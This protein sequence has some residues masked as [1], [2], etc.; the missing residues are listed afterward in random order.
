MKIYRDFDE[1]KLHDTVVA[2][3]KFD[4][5]HKGHMQLLKTCLN[6]QKQ[7][8]QSAVF[9][10]DASI[11]TIMPDTDGFLN[12]S[13]ERAWL[14]QC[15]G[16]EQLAEYS[17][18]KLSGMTPEAFVRDILVSQMGAKV[19]VVGEDFRFGYKRAGDVQALRAFSDKYGFQ[20]VVVPKFQDDQGKVSSSRIRQAV[21]HAEMERAADM[22]GRA[23]FVR[24][25]VITGK[26][27]GRTIGMP[28]ANMAVPADKLVPPN[29]VYVTRSQVD[30]ETHY[31]ITNIGTNPTV[32]GTHVGVETNLYDFDKDIY[33]C[34]MC[35]EF[36]TFVRPECKFDDVS[37][38]RA[39]MHKDA[40]YG[41]TYAAAKEKRETA[42]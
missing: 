22:M 7:G 13:S 18:Q 10:F 21:K 8:Y 20:L 35:T 9:T 23:Y 1:I 28:T 31:G 12:S 16:V 38:L 32:N 25:E 40:E 39:Q 4:G 2:C 36:L 14:L 33:G 15:M 41:R 27:L 26:Q 3:G 30:G 17:F 42:K 6:Y 37:A 11:L 34:V 29:G 24:G 19:V 5:I